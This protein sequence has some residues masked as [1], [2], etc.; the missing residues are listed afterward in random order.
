MLFRSVTSRTPAEYKQFMDEA[1]KELDIQIQ[2]LDRVSENEGLPGEEGA[3]MPAPMHGSALESN[4]SVMERLRSGVAIEINLGGK[5]SV[6][7]LNWI[8]ANAA[9]M[10]LTLDQQSTP[11]VISVRM[12]RRLYDSG[13][14]NFLETAPLF[15]RAVESLLK[16]AEK[17][18]RK[19]S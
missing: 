14:V 7:R 17:M 16:S 19:T 12:F 10:V 1:I 13:R 2:L 4:E 3:G 15:E 11:S 9:N 5:P 8:D 6:G 18:D